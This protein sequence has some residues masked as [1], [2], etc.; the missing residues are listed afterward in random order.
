MNLAWI[1]CNNSSP[2]PYCARLTMCDRAGWNKQ[3]PRSNLSYRAPMAGEEHKL[4]W[5]VARHPDGLELFGYLI[6]R[7][8]SSTRY[9]SPRLEMRASLHGTC[10]QAESVPAE[11]CSGFTASL[12]SPSD[13]SATVHGT[14]APQAH[15]SANHITPPLVGFRTR[16]S[17]SITTRCNICRSRI[18]RCGAQRP[19]EQRRGPFPGRFP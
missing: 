16:V 7:P 15:L 13:L 10:R 9:G 11:N 12:H 1:A 3:I 4:S 2:G 14:P 18:N 5:L 6:S 17:L 19:R 8:A